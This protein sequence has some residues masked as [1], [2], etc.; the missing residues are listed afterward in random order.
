MLVNTAAQEHDQTL[1]TS[2]K[3]CPELLVESDGRLIWSTEATPFF[4]LM[5]QVSSSGWLHTLCTRPS[6]IATTSGYFSSR[7]VPGGP[8]RGTRM[9]LI[10]ECRLRQT[11]AMTG[12]WDN[13]THLPRRPPWCP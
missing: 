10:S 2:V 12:Y 3:F 4:M 6:V 1:L 7:F 5:D 11:D 9:K 13:N 8:C